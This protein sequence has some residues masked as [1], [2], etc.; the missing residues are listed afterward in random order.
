VAQLFVL[1]TN[2]MQWFLERDFDEAPLSKL[3]L[4]LTLT[5]TLTLPLTLTLIL[6]LTL[7]L[8]LTL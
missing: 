7:T 3:T 6:T 2:T 5:L 1:S 4:A 8:T